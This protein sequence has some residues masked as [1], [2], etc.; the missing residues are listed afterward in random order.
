M[1]SEVRLVSLHPEVRDSS[2]FNLSSSSATHCP[3]FPIIGF[4]LKSTPK[5]FKDQTNSVNSTFHPIN[6]RF[7]HIEFRV[8]AT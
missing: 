7:I 8:V 6:A 1:S 3:I 5:V 2:P 4:Y